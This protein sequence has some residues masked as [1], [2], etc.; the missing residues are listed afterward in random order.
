M[1]D[2]IFRF[3]TEEYEDFKSFPIRKEDIHGEPRHKL[4]VYFDKFL[5]VER[6]E[7]EEVLEKEISHAEEL[8][9]QVLREL[10]LTDA[11]IELYFLSTGRDVVSLGEMALLIDKTKEECQEIAKKFVEKGLFKEIVGIT[12]H[13]A[14]LPPYAALMNQLKRFHAFISEIKTRVPVELNQSFFELENKAK[15][16]NQLK[17][18]VDFMEGLKD[19]MQA[20]MAEQKEDFE[21]TI[22]N[23]LQI[24]NIMQVMAGLEQEMREILELQIADLIQQFQDIKERISKN[25]EKLRLG[26]IQQTVEKAIAT[27]FEDGI[28]KITESLNK[29]IMVKLNSLLKHIEANIEE[30]TLSSVTSA[31]KIKQSFGAISDDF[32][33]AVKQSEEKITGISDT[34][35]KSFNVLKDLFSSEV[36]DTLQSVLGNILSRLEESENTTQEFWERAKRASILTMKDIWFIRSMEAAKASINEQLTRAKMRVLIVAPHLT[37][38]DVD[39]IKKCPSHV[40]IRIATNIDFTS[41]EHER[42]L[43]LLDEM[44]N[45][46]YRSR[47]RTDIWGINRDYEEVIICVLSKTEIRGK[48]YIEIAGI[49]SV[50]EEHIKIFVPILEETW[51]NSRKEVQRPKKRPKITIPQEL[52]KREE[53]IKVPEIQTPPKLKMKPLIQESTETISGSATLSTSP[54]IKPPVP[55]FHSLPG[56]KDSDLKV[57]FDELIIN[58]DKFTEKELSYA[59]NQLKSDIQ[60][61][62]GYSSVLDQIELAA[63]SLVKDNPLEKKEIEELRKKINFWGKKLKI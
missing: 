10:G 1:E 43:D 4:I 63:S 53:K 58:L 48:E 23:I 34:I 31:Q 33:N 52:P 49:G 55:E 12:P 20:H 16:I 22:S 42:I 27:V 62:L 54:E 56:D 19:T 51:M 30:I 32:N 28:K 35:L 41:P 38:I 46:S 24:E 50:I 15:G 36:I 2:V 60:A 17:E 7:V 9:K 45:I 26:V 11:E 59:L 13:Y 8:T 61:I 39:L 47:E 29:S 40:N 25:L 18:Y 3:T 37:D 6:F 57:K 21:N 14:P 44:P 5:T